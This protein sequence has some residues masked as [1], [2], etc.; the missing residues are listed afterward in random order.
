MSQDKGDMVIF[1]E[2]CYPVPGEHAFDG[3][4]HILTEWLYDFRKVPG[5]G[6]HVLMYDNLA[7]GINDAQ[8]HGSDMEVDTAI[9]RMLSCVKF[10]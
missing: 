10:H 3:D 5:C 8:I 9:I 1:T 2:I 6:V 7:F 4:H